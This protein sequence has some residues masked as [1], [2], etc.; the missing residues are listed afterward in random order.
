ML[1]Q[2]NPQHPLHPL[3]L[4][5]GRETDTAAN[6]DGLVTVTPLISFRKDLPRVHPKDL[7]RAVTSTTAKDLSIFPREGEEARAIARAIISP[8][9]P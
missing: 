9:A 6:W 5:D 4:W 3:P 7:A 1:V 2:S 8:R